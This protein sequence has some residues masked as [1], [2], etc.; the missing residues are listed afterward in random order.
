M[1]QDCQIIVAFPYK[2]TYHQGSVFINLSSRR[3][4]KGPTKATCPHRH[5]FTPTQKTKI[6]LPHS[7]PDC[8]FCPFNFLPVNNGYIT[9]WNRPRTL[10]LQSRTFHHV[11]RHWSS[12]MNTFRS[13]YCVFSK[14]PLRRLYELD[15]RRDSAVGTLLH[16]SNAFLAVGKFDPRKGHEDPE[17]E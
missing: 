7:C 15:C 14:Q 5:N 8:G 16:S 12:P 11:G 1:W 6:I 9:P 3:R 2:L 17:G 13:P 10:C 4:T